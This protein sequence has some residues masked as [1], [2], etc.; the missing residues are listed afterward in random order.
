MYIYRLDIGSLRKYS[1][2]IYP[3][4]D[5]TAKHKNR[6]ICNSIRKLNNMK[7][8]RETDYAEL[9][10]GYEFV[11]ASF[12]LDD[13]RVTKYLDAVEDQNV[14]YKELGI[15]PPMAV[16]ALAMAAISSSLTLPG[17]TVHISQNLEFCNAA[18][19]GETL[20]SYAKINRKL[21][22]GKFHMITIGISVLNQNKVPVQAGEICFILPPSAAEGK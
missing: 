9:K 10:N 14:I 4:Q 6:S 8:H 1:S 2:G 5:M 7:I 12:S 3:V 17:G 18:R 20:T 21:A 16:A 15:V 13:E 11:P 22:R 19:I